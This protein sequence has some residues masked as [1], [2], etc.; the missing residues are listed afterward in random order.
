MAKLK[1]VLLWLLGLL[2]LLPIAIFSGLYLFG[3]YLFYD[4]DVKLREIGQ[5][6]E[7]L[8]TG[9]NGYGGEPGLKILDSGY[10]APNTF[11]WIDEDNLVFKVDGPAK[12]VN[13]AP[14]TFVWNP[15]LG[16]IKPLLVEGHINCWF[17]GHLYFVRPSAWDIK[18]GAEKRAGI[19]QATLKELVDGWA[20]EG[21]RLIESIWQVPDER[22][23][24]NW[25]RECRPWAALKPELRTDDDVPRHN[26]IRLAQWNWVLRMP[27][28]GPSHY[29]F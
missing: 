8:A 24:L 12:G 7:Q 4:A 16:T 13:D 26:H 3:A 15:A 6:Q 29:D 14:A 17:D 9:G 10:R 2:I 20:V 18:P 22:Y 19:Y 1:K 23:T 11:F 28:I 21:P 5:R 27:D 25:R